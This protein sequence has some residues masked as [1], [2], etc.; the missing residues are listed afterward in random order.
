M[1]PPLAQ[2]IAESTTRPSATGWIGWPGLPSRSS[3]KCVLRFLPLNTRCTPKL[4][5]LIPGTGGAT[6]PTYFGE[7]GERLQRFLNW[8]ASR[9]NLACR[10]A[11]FL[12][13]NFRLTLSSDVSQTR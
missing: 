9:R 13:V 12:V 3:P 6:L 4:D 10:A 7:L 2:R 5:V 8:R 1:V 11:G